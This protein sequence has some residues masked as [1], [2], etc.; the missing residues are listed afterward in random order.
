MTFNL[1]YYTISCFWGLSSITL[2]FAFSVS[3][4]LIYQSK[5][6]MLKGILVLFVLPGWH[7]GVNL[8]AFTIEQ[9]PTEVTLAVL[10]LL[11]ALLNRSY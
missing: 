9:F 3:K 11:V 7:F 5:K 8:T 10:L 6:N 4:L 1:R 2:F